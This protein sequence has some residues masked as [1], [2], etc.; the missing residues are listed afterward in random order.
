M[1]KCSFYLFSDFLKVPVCVFSLPLNFCLCCSYL[2]YESR[3]YY[4]LARD[5]SLEFNYKLLTIVQTSSQSSQSSLTY[6]T[7]DPI[8][9][10]LAVYFPRLDPNNT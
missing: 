1:S 6:F 10:M 5:L 4:L 8:I 9:E 7:F 3:L 2:F